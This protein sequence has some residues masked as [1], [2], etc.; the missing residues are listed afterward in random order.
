MRNYHMLND[1]DLEMKYEDRKLRKKVQI[2][3][4]FMDFL[5]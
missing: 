1:T 5:N 2:L 4:I 3:P